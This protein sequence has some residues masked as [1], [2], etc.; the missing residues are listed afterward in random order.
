[1]QRERERSREKNKKKVILIFDCR[2]N[3]IDAGKIYNTSS[4]IFFLFLLL[5]PFLCVLRG[6]YKQRILLCT[7]EEVLLESVDDGGF[8]CFSHSS[9]LRTWLCAKKIVKAIA[10]YVLRTS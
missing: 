3:V 8:T 10:V 7:V 9:R 2:A 4:I 5:Y 1:M 6:V